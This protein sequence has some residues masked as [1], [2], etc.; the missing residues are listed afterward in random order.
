MNPFLHRMAASAL[1][2]AFALPAT[3]LAASSVAG[4]GFQASISFDYGHLGGSVETLGPFSGVAGA[5]DDG[6]YPSLL[7]PVPAPDIYENITSDG[8]DYAL[9]VNWVDAD[10]FE[11]FINGFGA[12]DLVNLSI[13]LSGVQFLDGATPVPISAASFNRVGSILDEVN[14]GGREG[15]AAGSGMPSPSVSF[16]STS[17]TATFASMSSQLLGDGPWLRFD[18]QTAAVPEPATYALMA[19]GLGG[20]AAWRRRQR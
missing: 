2:A 5:A 9:G 3:A 1:C 6:F 14:P 4:Q 13:T 16:T 8:I 19:L 18:V 11:L 20:L 17:I 15:F 12:Q 7:Y 10:T